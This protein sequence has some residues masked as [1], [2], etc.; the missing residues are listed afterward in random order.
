M[1][2]I[3]RVLVTAAAVGVAAWVLGGIRVDGTTGRQVVSVLGVGAILALVHLLVRPIVR[4]LAI[5]LYVLTLGLVTFVINALMLMLAAW[6][7]A[8]LDLAFRIQDFWSA[9]L[10]A[11]IVSVVSVVLS[12]VVGD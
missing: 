8:R 10:G 11:L 5:P 2:L 6:I 1:R 4:T 9:L 12:K 7:G 3:V